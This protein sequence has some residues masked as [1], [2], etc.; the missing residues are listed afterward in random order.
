[1]SD[2]EIVPIFEEKSTSQIPPYPVGSASADRDIT[3]CSYLRGRHAKNDVLPLRCSIP[4]YVVSADWKFTG[5]RISG[6]DAF[7]STKYH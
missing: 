5:A 3:G 7:R 2:R 1:M 6:F 4:V